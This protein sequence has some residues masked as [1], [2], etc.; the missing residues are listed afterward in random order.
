MKSSVAQRSAPVFELPQRKMELAARVT[1]RR[2]EVR[3]TRWG[4]RVW[5]RAEA[6]VLTRSQRE[7]VGGAVSSRMAISVKVDGASVFMVCEWGL[8]LALWFQ[9]P[10][11]G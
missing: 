8:L 11:S 4:R 2:G 9:I 3:G 6:I 10:D 1:S 5:V 7:G